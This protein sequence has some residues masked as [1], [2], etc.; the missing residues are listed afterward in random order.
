MW[1]RLL[2]QLEINKQDP[3]V[4][5]ETYMR[6]LACGVLTRKGAPD[7]KKSK[8]KGKGKDKD[9]KGKG[10]GKAVEEDVTMTDERPHLGDARGADVAELAALESAW[11]GYMRRMA[12][13]DQ[14]KD[15]TKY[16]ADMS[17]IIV[18]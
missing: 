18:F 4:I 13:A 14:G 8:D 6:A 2:R 1:A 12:E 17:L 7:V 3:A 5:G 9:K 11:A 15:H 10:K 16:Q